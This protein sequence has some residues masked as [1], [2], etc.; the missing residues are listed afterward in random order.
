M[1]RVM[2]S[3]V[4]KTIETLFPY[5]T[6]GEK[7]SL[8]SENSTKLR[9]LAE[10]MRGIP[11]ELL[12][13]PPEKYADLI[14]ARSTVEET[15]DYW[16][17]H[18]KWQ[19]LRE[20]NNS[21]AIAVIRDVLKLCPDEPPPTPDVELAF[22]PDNNLRENIRRDVSATRRALNNA[23]W[24]AATILAGATIEALLHWRLSSELQ[25]N[26]SAAIAASSATPPSDLNKWVLNDFILVAAQLG[27]IKP[28]T[29]TAA[30][31]AKD[32]RNLIHPGRA[33]RLNQECDRGTSYTGVGAL[34][35]VLVDLS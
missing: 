2:P 17:A 11:S 4:V 23:E 13:L 10:L 33:I 19:H 22:I 28:D 3:Q 8:F 6:R 1:L 5:V 27:A 21:D 35:R 25:P 24:K 14:F 26:L 7:G 30:L 34:E 15:L 9:G 16:I 18:G 12:V 32:F 29:A 31:L 20:V